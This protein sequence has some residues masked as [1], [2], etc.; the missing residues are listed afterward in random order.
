MLPDQIQAYLQQLHLEKGKPF[1]FLVDE[2][3]C[4]QGIWGAPNSG[5]FSDLDIGCNMI[6]IAPFLVGSMTAEIEILPFVSTRDGQV[7][8]AHFIPQKHE[9]LVLLISVDQTHDSLQANQQT[10]NEV[11]LLHAS[12]KK[13]IARQ[14]E[15][16]N[17]LVE[18]KS[19]LD[20]R[21]R[22]AEANIA[23]KNEF[24]G[25]MSHEFRTPLASIINYADLAI[26]ESTSE[27]DIK[28]CSE[29]IS[30]GARHLASLVETILDD[31]EKEAINRN[32]KKR[33][34]DLRSL[35]DDMTAIMAPLAAEKGLA[36]ATTVDLDV[37]SQLLADVVFLRQI[38]INLLGNAVKFTDSGSVKL[39]MSWK[40]GVLQVKIID[41]GP[42]ISEA[43]QKN[44]FNAFE[45]GEQ[46][47]LPTQGTGLGL[48]ISLD[49]AR[50]MNG[51]IHLNSEVG[52]G[53]TI[54]LSIPAP[55]SSN[56]EFDRHSN[57]KNIEEL[58]AEKAYSILICDDDQDMVALFEHYLL[59]AGYGVLVAS[60]GIEANSKAIKYNPDLVLM[61]ICTPKMNGVDAARHLRASGFSRPIIAIS[62][63]S[64]TGE[65][66]AY[67]SAAL[68]KP[69]KIERLLEQI[70]IH[71]A[72]DA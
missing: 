26:D 31:A 16:I 25:M 72:K 2:D 12:Q 4:L 70:K 21:R 17:E 53:S 57:T 29:A 49:L 63:M 15:L 59:V 46:N 65:E 9:H 56:Q 64:V 52:S 71:L 10:A 24:I 1:C 6:D 27:S 7:F 35:A 3:Y 28:M 38:L 37:P 40:L 8:E 32:T 69:F 66:E 30:R 51:E 67:F 60:D 41:T 34:F 13:L 44:I 5:L 43:D 48:A 19:E 55:L 14:R 58:K 50:T 20:H 45:R 11:K 47:N 22:E 33:A 62:A 68:R 42:G 36:F 54:T 18:A 23:K 61:D 39:D